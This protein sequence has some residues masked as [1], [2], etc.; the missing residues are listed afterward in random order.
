MTSS[1]ETPL[2]ENFLDQAEGSWTLPSFW[3]TDLE[4]FAREKEKIFYKNWWYVGAAS[5]V[6]KPGEFLTATVIDQDIFVIRGGDQILRAFYNVCRHRAHQLVHGRGCNRM[7]VCPYHGWTYDIEGRLKGGRNLE[8]MKNFD[9]RDFGLVAVRVETLAGL[10]FVNL[11]TDA[12]PLAD[13]SRSMIKDM[14]AHCPGLD[15]LVLA[16]RHELETAANWKTLVDNDLESYHSAAAHPSLM[17]LLDYS[18]FEVWEDQWTTC[19]AMSSANLENPAYPVDTND[20]V[21]RAIYTWLWPNTAFFVAPGGSNLGVF[22]MIPT[23]PESSIQR[24]DFYFE[25]EQPSEREQAYL[26]WTIDTL[27]PED[28]TLYE[29]VQ[30]GLRSRGYS[31]GRFV[32]A[33]DRPEWSEHHVHQFQK[34][35]RDA[36]LACS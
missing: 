23:G 19:H 9:R 20:P 24:W 1:V 10:V 18:S 7:L 2:P 31:Q 12:V 16:R 34:L 17:G 27:I 4:I 8:G 29:N 33:R 11:D 26:D 30:R 35:V 32:I 6:S 21:K 28:T 5:Q 25:N 3:Y 22:Q 14:R 15:D 36:L 13:I